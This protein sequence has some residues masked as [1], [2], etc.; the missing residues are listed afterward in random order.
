MH[1]AGV[2]PYDALLV[3]SFGGPEQ[4]DDVLPFLENVTRGRNVP[5]ERLLEVAEHYHHFGGKSPINDQNRALIDALTREFEQHG[6]RLP[7][8]F[9]NRNWHPFLADSVRE[10]AAQGVRRAL[11][12]FTSAFSSYSGCRQY[13]ENI[14]AAQ[15]EVGPAAPRLDRLRMFFNHPLFIETMVGRV[16]QSLET[17]PA[18]RRAGTP[19]VFTAHSIPLG[20]AQNCEYEAQ[21]REACRLVAASFP[22]HAWQ[23]TYQSRSGPPT[24]PWLAPDILDALRELARQG[25]KDVVVLP[26]G[27]ISDHL[28]V[29]Y[30]LD[31]EARQL[32]DSL[33]L[34]MV[35]A[36]T[37]G[38]APK[39]VAMIRELVLERVEPGHPRRA[40]GT[41][42]PSH[43]VCAADCCLPPQR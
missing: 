9:G 20:M 16:S 4:P 35:R 37:A 28:E 26:I 3:L 40:L 33:G 43:D 39:F 34:N 30:D 25:T 22:G 19:L 15:R 32:S 27:F 21:L 17:I 38:T 14:E 1:A 12:F 5:R 41:L 2:E 31:I 36:G 11:V 10:M 13:R 29:L 6:P 7:I 8:Y 23:L 42:G 18:D 24:Q